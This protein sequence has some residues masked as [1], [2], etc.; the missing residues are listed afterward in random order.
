MIHSAQGDT[1][2]LNQIPEEILNVA[3]AF[4]D[5]PAAGLL[6]PAP[7][8]GRKLRELLQ[9]EERS[10]ILACL[11]TCKGNMSKAAQEL[12]MARNTLYRKMQKLEI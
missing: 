2:D 1:L 6:E 7:A 3:G 10:E 5:R 8:A 4:P 9:E 11:R 12:G